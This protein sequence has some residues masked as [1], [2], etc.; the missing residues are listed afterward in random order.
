MRR[1]LVLAILLAACGAA[2]ADRP[3]TVPSSTAEASS[4]S[5]EPTAAT[6]PAESTVASSTT[7]A[8]ATTPAARAGSAAGDHSHIAVVGCSQTRDAIFGYNALVGDGRFGIN[9]HARYLSGGS[10][11]IWAESGKKK[12]ATFED[13]AG[14]ET[15]A[16]WIMLCWHVQRSPGSDVEAVAGI[17]ETALAAIGRDVP[18]YVSGLNDWD[19]RDLCRKA[20]YPASWE[21]ADAVVAEGLALLGPNLGP[22]SEEETRDGCHGNDAGNRVMGEQLAAFFG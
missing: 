2:A 10:I 4:T 7:E 17:I 1:V 15:D 3:G 9:D 18:V 13:L 12:W 6:K 20:D 11:D 22:I 14:S 8:V 21:L 5:A 19:P 16:L